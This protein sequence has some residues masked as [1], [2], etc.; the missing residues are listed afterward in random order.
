MPE[1]ETKAAPSEPGRF[2]PPI[3]RTHGRKIDKLLANRKL[4]TP[5]KERVHAAKVK[6]QTWVKAMDDLTLEGESLLA[7]L[8]DLLNEYKLFIEIDLIYD[9]PDDFLYRQS[10]QHKVGNSILE[11]FLPRLADTRLVPGLALLPSYIVGP[12]SA[13]AAFTVIGNVHT[14]LEGSIFIK[15]KN[16]DYAISKRLY[17]KAS[18]TPTFEQGTALDISMNVAYLAAECKT[19]LDK[20]MFNEGLETSRALKQ[21]VASARYLLI[22]EWLDMKPID[23]KLT[24]IDEAIILRWR[25]LPSDFRE[26]LDSVVGR[27]NARAEFVKHLGD[28]PL[29]LEAFQRIV[30]HLNQVFPP[31]VELDET[32][33]L[34]RGYF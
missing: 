33:V 29:K 14:P 6:Y 9:S 34:E 24:S 3:A 12:Q 2:H 7:K 32:T 22:C 16:Q 17:L 27:K 21:A 26:Q 31:S 4:P 10:G 20:T 25:R 23:S 5:D 8:V 18:T 1:S 30:M 15:E 11:E 28:H 13:F 19:N